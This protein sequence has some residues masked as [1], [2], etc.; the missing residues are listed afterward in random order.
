MRKY[1]ITNC[2]N[3]PYVTSGSRLYAIGGQNGMFPEKGEHVPK[4]MWGVWSHPIKLL[5]GFWAAMDGEWLTQA[6]TH[7]AF[8]YATSFDYKLQNGLFAERFQ[9]VPDNLA[10][11]AVRY[12]FQNPS[13]M[14]SDITLEFLAHSDLMPVWLSDR[15]GKADGQDSAVWRDDL[16][17]ISFQDKLNP[18]YCLV[19]CSS[20]VF[21]VNTDTAHG[22]Q[23]CSG[24]GVSASFVSHIRIPAAGSAEI[25]YYITGSSVSF[26]DAARTY[27]SI[28]CDVDGLLYEKMTRYDGIARRAK[29]HIKAA[30]S[31]CL[32]N[33]YEWSKYINDWLIR[34]VPYVGRGAGAGLPEFPWWFGHDAAYALPAYLIC[35]DYELVKDT[36]RLLK[37]YS[38][39]INGNGRVVHEISTNGVVF[40]EGMIT[41]TP[42]FAEIIWRVYCWTG[43]TDF[44]IEMYPFCRAGMEWV[45]SAACPDGEG[46][47]VGYGITEIDMLDLACCDT[48]VHALRGLEVLALMA[49][50]LGFSQDMVR[51]EALFTQYYE[52]FERSFWMETEGVYGD[53]VATPEEILERASMWKDTLRGFPLM[54]ED[55]VDGTESCKTDKTPSDVGGKARLR[56][57][58]EKIMEEAA[59]SPARVKRP[60]LLFGIDHTLLPV[61][62]GYI[63]GDRA[64]R[65]LDLKWSNE[66]VDEYGAKGS[67]ILN[68]SVMPIMSA[69]RVI[70]EGKAGRPDK[71]RDYIR[72]TAATFN[73]VTPGTTSEISPNMGC[74]V[75]TWNNYIT[76]WPYI[77]TFLGMEPDAAGR[78]VVLNPQLPQDFEG[79]SLMDISIGSNMFDFQCSREDGCVV[80]RA[81][82]TQSGWNVR[83]K[84]HCDTKLII[85][86]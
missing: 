52:K 81:R 44:L 3:N 56:A 26:E 75:Q 27:K 16:R 19:G 50:R 15:L 28:I 1:T 34:D 10:G 64:I 25:W 58:M 83:L 29:L 79:F 37:D 62:Y 38:E 77:N 4:E 42:Q 2:E 60:W 32:E 36:L 30:D 33:M 21:S 63:C 8:P 9:F 73:L 72:R 7:T 80:V 69:H 13:N 59:A 82:M 61:E 68:G 6:S 47:P 71:A 74:F 86:V 54:E 39:R 45:Y 49:E 76:M 35:G 40:Y 66:H 23:N 53:M 78:S 46:L 20:P 14:D 41:E 17:V 57:H 55:H 5:D 70:A 84:D 67:S 65:M 51:F 85:E 31:H 48:A 43:D 22:P 24:H 11:L 12:L 18:W